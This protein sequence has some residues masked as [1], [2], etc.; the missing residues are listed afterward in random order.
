MGGSV[1]RD[2]CATAR[3]VRALLEQVGVSDA[4]V[5]LAMAPW[6]RW[7]VLDLAYGII[8][9]IGTMQRAALSAAV[10]QG[11]NGVGA[12]ADKLQTA[13][14]EFECQCLNN[15]YFTDPADYPERLYEIAQAMPFGSEDDR[16][17]VV[18]MIDTVAPFMRSILIEQKVPE[19]GKQ[20]E[21][22]ERVAS[23]PGFGDPLAWEESRLQEEQR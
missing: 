15:P 13:H 2:R 22:L 10:R 1:F 7:M 18:S 14:A 6:A 4:E 17:R 16:R 3:E 23:H 19:P 5:R 9:R 21:D 12:Q 20:L 8:N 11:R